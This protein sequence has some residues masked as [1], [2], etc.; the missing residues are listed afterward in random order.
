MLKQYEKSIISLKDN[1]AMKDLSLAKMDHLKEYCEKNNI[2][3]EHEVKDI[4]NLS[5]RSRG[6]R[7]KKSKTNKNFD[8]PIVKQNKVKNHSSHQKYNNEKRNKSRVEKIK[9]GRGLAKKT[10][11]EII[12]YFLYKD[13]C[14]VMA[15]TKKAIMMKN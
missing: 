10:C 4:E 7:S 9:E 12:E 13:L 6:S 11:K 1:E 3:L 2:N 8:S 15:N 5:V 14:K